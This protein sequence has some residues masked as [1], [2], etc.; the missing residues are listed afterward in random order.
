[1]NREDKNPGERLI[2]ALDYATAGEALKLVEALSG[3]VS[4]YKIGLQ[5]YTSAGPEIIGAIAA[6]GAKIFLDLKLHDIPNTVAKAVEAAAQLG[7]AMLTLHLAGGREMLEAAAAAAPPDLLLL[8]VTVLTS[9]DETTLRETG[10]TSGVADQAL[11]LAQLG[12]AAGIRGF[13]ASPHE[14]RPL[15]AALGYNVTIITPGVRPVWAGA[16]DQKRFTTPAQAVG[17]GADYLVVGRP[18]T[19]HADP[20]EAVR[21][22]VAELA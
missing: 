11:R 10:V 15:R 17:D 22:I 1:M 16:D 18:I 7:V 8:G 13:I 20:R 4:F 6:T 5:L 9:S 3:E 21:A 12:V 2:V 19:A 14:L